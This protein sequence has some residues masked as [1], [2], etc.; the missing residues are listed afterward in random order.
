MTDKKI[1]GKWVIARFQH[2][3]NT[4]TPIPTPLEAFNPLWG[5]DA[6]K[7]QENA[8]TAMGAFIAIAKQEAVEIITPVC[9][10]SNPSGTVCAKAYDRI[11]DSIVA[12]VEQGCDAILL[13]LHGA[14]VSERVVDG[15]GNLLRRIKSVAPNTP[16]GTRFTR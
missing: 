3:T 16:S 11:C 15:E 2:E 4:F 13:D 8:R 12:A 6:Y 10:F 9:A 7:D 1:G 14:M 5:A